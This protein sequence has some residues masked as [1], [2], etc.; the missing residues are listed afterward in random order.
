MNDSIKRDQTETKK[1]VYLGVFI[2]IFALVLRL[3]YVNTVEVEQ[4]IRADAEKY[5]HLAYNLA[6]NK[7]Y[8]LSE[9]AP[10]IPSTYITPGY[11]MLLASGL[12]LNIDFNS[13]YSLI[14]NFQA[15]LSS[16]T[17]LFFYLI[18]LR[19]LPL[20]YAV[21]TSIVIIVSPHLIAASGYV[22]TETLF[23][24]YLV[25]TTYLSIQAL[26]K[27]TVLWFLLT[28]IVCG[29]ASLTRPVLLLYPIIPI[30]ILWRFVP[31]RDLLKLTT[32]LMIGFL[33]VWSP[34]QIWI[35]QHFNA[36]EPNLGPASLSLGIYP[37]FIYKD[38]ELRGFP[39]R[40]DSDYDRFSKSYSATIDVLTERAKQEPWKYIKWYLFGKP[41]TFWQANNDLAAAGGPFIY[42]VITSRYHKSSA[43]L[44]SMIGVFK[45]HTSLVVLSFIA[46][47]MLFIFFLKRNETYIEGYIFGG[48]IIYFTLIHTILAPLPRYSYP[49]IPYAYVLGIFMIYQIIRYGQ[50]LLKKDKLQ[51]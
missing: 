20:I 44:Y 43:W 12:I 3:A 39:Y 11:P 7:S 47:I 35:N 22:L 15:L 30:I 10:F 49:V 27:K 34:W 33:L 41:A 36:N 46:S 51:T 17:V 24:F 5:F 19:F 9:S 45:I 18:S 42:P 37:D 6:F 2:F 28:G 29:F 16:I 26:K 21:L 48:L 32:A 1:E 25:L 14:L 8:S 38:P 23:I 31:I 50:F 4:P 40:D 13:F